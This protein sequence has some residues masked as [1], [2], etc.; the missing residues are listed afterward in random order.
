[1]PLK[2]I[3]SKPQIVRGLGSNLH[4]D[5]STGH[6]RAGRLLPTKVH[7]S[8]TKHVYNTNHRIKVRLGIYD[9]YILVEWVKERVHPKTD[10]TE[11]S[12]VMCRHNKHK[13]FTFLYFFIL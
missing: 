3:P 7:H 5:V 11:C 1:M 2:H 8:R 13:T 12:V 9:A 10:F 4:T 6:Y